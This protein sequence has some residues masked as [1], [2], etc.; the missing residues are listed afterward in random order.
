MKRFFTCRRARLVAI[1]VT[2]VA[3][4]SFAASTG[5]GVA[6]ASSQ[7]NQTW[8][9]P[10]WT[11]LGWTSGEWY[12]GHIHTLNAPD[13]CLEVDGSGFYGALGDSSDE[14]NYDPSGEQA[15]LW[16]CEPND[17]AHDY[18][19]NQL[20]QQQDNGDGSWT[21][22]LQ[23]SKGN[24]CLDSLAGHH[25]EASP[26]E[27]F[28]CNGGNAQKWTIGPSGQLQSVDSPGYCLDDRDWNAQDGAQM[29]LWWC[30]Y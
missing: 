25:F 16:D 17:S 12:Y 5:A 29:Q 30:A 18:D 26:V 11:Y 3:I 20:W 24:Y 23:H 19:K 15:Q 8:F 21:F 2:L 14:I 9:G 6:H 22:Y 10:A 13:K 4:L 7:A 27:I 28:P 1:T